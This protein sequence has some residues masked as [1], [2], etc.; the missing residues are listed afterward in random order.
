MMTDLTSNSHQW[1][2]TENANRGLNSLVMKSRPED[3]PEMFLKTPVFAT[4]K[5]DGTNVAKDD[6]GQVYSRRLKIGAEESHFQKTSLE[7]VRTADIRRFR[8]S[9][10]ATA[11]L[12]EE[13]LGLC[14]V[15]G[16]LVC[17][18]QYYD[19]Q[20]RGLSGQWRVFGACLLLASPHLLADCLQRLSDRQFAAIK[21]NGDTIQILPCAA[22][23]EVALASGVQVSPVLASDKPLAQIVQENKNIMKKGEIEGIILTVF[24]RKFGYNLL[25]WK[26]KYN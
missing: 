24:S 21:L 22:L 1:P 26:G 18:P 23:F 4:E 16:E 2:H 19:Y 20:H 12:E 8:D 11:C 6:R 17:H 3:L 5:L 9:L 13:R 14:L 25:K 10:C 7:V 15:Y